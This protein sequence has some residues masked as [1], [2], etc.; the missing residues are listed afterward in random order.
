MPP[1]HRRSK[2]GGFAV[3][4]RGFRFFV[5][6]VGGGLAVFAAAVGRSVVTLVFIGGPSLFSLVFADLARSAISATAS[7]TSAESGRTVPLSLFRLLDAGG[8]C[9]AM[10][11]NLF[12]SVGRDTPQ[13]C[14]VLSSVPSIF[15]RKESHTPCISRAAGL[16]LPVVPVLDPALV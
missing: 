13:H 3:F 10:M 8:L 7:A 5:G 16:G 11:P 9:G 12:V 6:S 14:S 15:F 2:F 1:C 4:G